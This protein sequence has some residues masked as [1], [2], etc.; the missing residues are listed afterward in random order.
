M[1]EWRRLPLRDAPDIQRWWQAK[2]SHYRTNP[3]SPR[4]RSARRDPLSGGSQ[5]L[6]WE[7]SPAQESAPTIDP[8]RAEGASIPPPAFTSSQPPP[9]GVPSSGGSPSGIFYDDASRQAP[10]DSSSERHGQHGPRPPIVPNVPP[11]NDMARSPG[12]A[13][14]SQTS[15]EAGSADQVGFLART[16]PSLYF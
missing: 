11:G 9:L 5:F 8:I 1:N 3:P 15:P 6:D 2:E 10:P 4:A 16:Q 13:Q 14:A 12:E 7:E